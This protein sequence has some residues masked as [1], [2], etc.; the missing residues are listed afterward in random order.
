MWKESKVVDK[1]AKKHSSNEE[2]DPL[3]HHF[4]TLSE[5]SVVSPEIMD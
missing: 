2:K 1:G 4:L 5:Q 3:F